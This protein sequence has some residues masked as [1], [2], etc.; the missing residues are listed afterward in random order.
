MP[1][2]VKAEVGTFFAQRFDRRTFVVRVKLAA[3][4]LSSLTIFAVGCSQ[5]ETATSPNANS[6]VANTT[7]PGPDNSEITTRVDASGVKTEERVFRNN[8]RVSKVVVTTKDGTRTVKAYSPSGEEREVKGNEAEDVLEATGDKVASGAGFVA[9]KSED[10]A[11]EAKDV[12]AKA[13]DKTAEVGSKTADAAKT[14]GEKSV[15]GA[16]KVGDK[17]VE[18]AK[19]VG[20]KTVE[21]AKKAGSAV[22]KV[23]P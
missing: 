1:L 20:D 6:A 15:E 13:V 19:K 17:T 12:G 22:K 8:P 16:K 9:D 3:L 11:G 4:M 18:G 21:G 2:T 14:V 5:T 23:V 10:V 7:K